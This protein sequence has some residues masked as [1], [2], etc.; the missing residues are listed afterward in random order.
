[1]LEGKDVGISDAGEGGK[2]CERVG[3][4]HDKFDLIAWGALCLIK[5]LKK[6]AQCGGKVKDSL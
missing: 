6:W 5:D 2:S 1:M 4:L 3:N